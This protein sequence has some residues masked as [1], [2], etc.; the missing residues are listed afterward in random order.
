ML[1]YTHARNYGSCIRLMW[2]S[3]KSFEPH[4]PKTQRYPGP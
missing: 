1:E 4:V 2:S 3:P